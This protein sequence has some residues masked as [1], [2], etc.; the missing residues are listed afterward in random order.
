MLDKPFGHFK[1]TYHVNFIKGC[2]VATLLS[3]ALE[4]ESIYTDKMKK[5][6]Y[7]SKISFLV[8]HLKSWGEISV[9]EADMVIK[10]NFMFC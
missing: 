1:N 4:W 3:A 8:P 5:F 7:I 6:L 9:N 10:Q 2:N